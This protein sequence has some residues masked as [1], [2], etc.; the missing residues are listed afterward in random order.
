MK[1]NPK[2]KQVLNLKDVKSIVIDIGTFLE[3]MNN[4]N[5]KLYDDIEEQK[6][7]L[8]KIIGDE[9]E[10]EDGENQFSMLQNLLIKSKFDDVKGF[11]FEKDQIRRIQ[12]GEI[13]LREY[14]ESLSD[15]LSE[16]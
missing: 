14:L 4:S 16:D 15:R 12:I 10:N 9:D 8:E 2:V 13:Q 3:N 6:L 11:D 7:S 5:N 1:K